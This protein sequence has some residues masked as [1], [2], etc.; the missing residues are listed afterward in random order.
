MQTLIA[1]L[2]ARMDAR[3]PFRFAARAEGCVMRV[4]RCGT[5]YLT[6]VTNGTD[7]PR[8]LAL[9]HTHPGPTRIIWGDQAS[10]SRDGRDV[11]LARRET[12]V[13]LW[14]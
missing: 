2:D 9:K 1:R 6:V 3:I 8:R 4:M 7:Q 14:G 5:R 13:L 10:V 11:N 12:V